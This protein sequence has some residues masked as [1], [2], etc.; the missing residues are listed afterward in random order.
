MRK[1]M[2]HKKLIPN[3][4]H[5]PPHKH[6]EVMGLVKEQFFNGHYSVKPGS[7]SVADTPNT[8][9]K[10]VVFTRVENGDETAQP[11]GIA[12]T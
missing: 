5:V 6:D 8:K 4:A 3:P 2:T 7:V 12:L 9:E 11:H 1:T 10:I